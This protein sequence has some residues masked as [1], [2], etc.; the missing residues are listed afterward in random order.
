MRAPRPGFKH[1]ALPQSHRRGCEV[2]KPAPLYLSTSR[3]CCPVLMRYCS[4][5]GERG[6]S[7]S[8][9]LASVSRSLYNSASQARIYNT[10]ADRNQ[11]ALATTQTGP[12]DPKRAP[13][14]SPRRLWRTGIAH[15]PRGRGETLR[16]RAHFRETSAR[17][18][19]GLSHSPALP[20]AYHTL[21]LRRTIWLPRAS[22]ASGGRPMDC[23]SGVA[24]A[25]PARLELTLKSQAFQACRQKE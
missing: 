4:H 11:S 8:R 3:Y 25:T 14:D 15:R 9:P 19:G 22:G 13:R 5:A 24:W 6:S 12:T 1:G 2:E 18:K 10:R 21:Q 16:R 23:Q 7:G 20:A 17:R